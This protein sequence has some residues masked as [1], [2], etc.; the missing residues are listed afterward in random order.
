V[1]ASSRGQRQ[2]LRLQQPH[3]VALQ[4]QFQIDDVWPIL[5]AEADQLLVDGRKPLARRRSGRDDAALVLRWQADEVAQR[6]LAGQG[7][8]AGGYQVG[9]EL[10][11]GNPRLG[12]LAECDQ[13]H[14]LAGF[15]SLERLLR[16]LHL[17]LARP[18]G[19]PRLH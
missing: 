5:L 9:L 11:V 1:V 15:R 12:H 3:V 18:D 13:A 17:D 7:V 6:S 8:G 4:R 2:V 19:H 16:L 14:L 10:R